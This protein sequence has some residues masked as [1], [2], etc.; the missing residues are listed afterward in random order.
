MSNFFKKPKN[1]LPFIPPKD[2]A[3][4]RAKWDKEV[5]EA[6]KEGKYYTDV[7]EMMADI[8]GKK[9]YRRLSK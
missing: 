9:K 8:L 1:G 7:K 5:A 2:P 3:K 4:L 6:L